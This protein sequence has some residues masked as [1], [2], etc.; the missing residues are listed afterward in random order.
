[1]GKGSKSRITNIKLYKNN[2]DEI[3]WSNTN[4][5]L[6]LRERMKKSLES[7]KPTLKEIKEQYTASIRIRK[8]NL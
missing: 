8:E 2:Y 1:M 4:A 7:P 6:W 5:P 3:E